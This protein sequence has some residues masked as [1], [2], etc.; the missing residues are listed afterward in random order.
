MSAI[1]KV[2]GSAEMP[3]FQGWV[4]PTPEKAIDDSVSV[5]R[6]RKDDW[7]RVSVRDRIALLGDLLAGV[8][9]VADRW[10]AAALE[11][12]G[13]SPGTPPEGEEWLGGPFAVV[14]NLRLLSR[15]L[16]DLEAYGA[17]RLPGR[18]WTREG[19]QVV[20]P[21]FPTNLYDRVLFTG[22]TGEIWMQPQVTLA[23]LRE[24]QAVAYRKKDLAGKVALVLGAGNVSSIG[25]MDALYKLFVEN[26]VV[27]LKM[28]PVNEYV[29][30]FIE[31]AFRPLVDRGYLRV[32]YGG[33]AEG[34][35]L[36]HHPDVD[37][38]HIT[39]SD[40]TH[41]AIVFGTGPEGARRKAE[42]RPVLTKRITSELGNVTPVIVVPGSWSDGDIAFQ[43]VNLA[44]MLTNNAGFNCNATRVIVTPEGWAERRRL[45]D[46]VRRTLA[47]AP[48]RKAYYPG[49]ED[50]F[51]AFIEAHPEAERIGVGGEGKIPWTLVASVDAGKDGDICFTTEAF[52]GLMAETALP[53]RTA[54]EYLERAVEFCNT[55]VWGTLSASIVVHPSSLRDP[56][57]ARAV[58]R[59]VAD[60]RYGSVA[61]NHWSA[62]SYGFVSTTWGAFPGHDIYDIQS[63]IGVVHN[64]Y[65]FDAPQKS[66][67]RG[68][69]RVRPTP[70][71][72]V[73]HKTSHELG[74][75]LFYFEASPSPLRLPGIIWTAMW[76]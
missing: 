21:V 67:V 17:P 48:T 27:V 64:T 38:I 53:A 69:F 33:A 52:C 24:T 60:L 20:A 1:A 30:P 14:R 65:L 44:S 7:V 72:F 40:K 13:I 49:A 35:H 61:V 31:E 74:R 12:K 22:F 25:P 36:C 16:A 66:V 6:A 39:G 71:W 75:K 5:L 63:G 56:A 8:V 10:V 70:P 19:G 46:A 42:R 51:R 3:R 45:L 15:S 76:G 11:A 37:E 9:R 58:E 34:A 57:V 59:A 4:P 54:A 32:V 2:R 43:G 29:G 26:Q 55:K 41:D 28:N 68:P 47:L 73:T 23:S 50:R 18:P 62:L